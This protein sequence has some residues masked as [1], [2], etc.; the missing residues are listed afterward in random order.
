[1][2]PLSRYQD[3]V[4][5]T[6]P[7]ITAAFLHAVQDALIRLY[8][9][10]QSLKALVVDGTGGSAVTP[11]AGDIMASRSLRAGRAVAGNSA[12][13]GAVEAGELVKALVP[14]GW[15]QM[16]GTMV[17]GV[18]VYDAARTAQGLY[19]ITFDVVLANPTK[20]CPVVTIYNSG[21]PRFYNSNAAATGVGG[22]VKVTVQVTDGV[23]ANQDAP[24]VLVL[25]GD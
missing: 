2:W 6:V 12:P 11:T 17:R 16:N 21:T 13:T 4:D 15:I 1:M 5:N 24:F 23:P 7:A 3:F 14:V 18:N 9:G 10:T 25:F 19:D 22:R 20:S 8:D